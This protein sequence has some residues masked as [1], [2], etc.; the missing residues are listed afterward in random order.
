LGWQNEAGGWVLQNPRWYGWLDGK[1]I[2]VISRDPLSVAVFKHNLDYLKWLTLFHSPTHTV[3]VLN[4][5]DFLNAGIFL[6]RFFRQA[7]L[8]YHF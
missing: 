1:A 8:F 2:T 7:E 5:A 6:C 4:T 3:I